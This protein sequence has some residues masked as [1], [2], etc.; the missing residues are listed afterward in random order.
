MLMLAV[1]GST[2]SVRSV[3]DDVMVTVV[4]PFAYDVATWALK[5][6]LA[7]DPSR[8]ST[9]TCQSPAGTLVNVTVCSSEPLEWGAVLGATTSNPMTGS[10]RWITMVA[11]LAGSPAV[12]RLAAERGALVAYSR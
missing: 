3:L 12:A 11:V 1:S 9:T 10:M 6:R 4:V 7:P 2:V 5:P 8:H